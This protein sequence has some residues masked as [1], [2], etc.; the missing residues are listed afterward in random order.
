MFFYH[1]N[2]WFQLIFGALHDLQQ[3]FLIRLGCLLQYPINFHHVH[4]D[5]LFR[6]QT[7]EEVVAACE[8]SLDAI[9]Q[10]A[11]QFSENISLSLQ[12]P[13]YIN[14]KSLQTF[15]ILIYSIHIHKKKLPPTFLYTS[16]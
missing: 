3:N 1:L 11:Q 5:R 7:F 14:K 2:T 16:T 8:V 12:E 9:R 6:T 15:I 4:C 13:G 10:L